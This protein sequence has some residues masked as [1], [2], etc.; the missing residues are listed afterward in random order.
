MTQAYLCCH[1]Q[2]I[3]CYALYVLARSGS[4]ICNDGNNRDT[5]G[6]NLMVY[7]LV[8]ELCQE[9]ASGLLVLPEQGNR[10]QLSG[11]SAPA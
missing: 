9:R 10:W 6:A 1:E 4:G 3:R 2:L 5:P 11:F 8:L 7:S